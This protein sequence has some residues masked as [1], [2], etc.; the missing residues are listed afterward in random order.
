M[1][2]LQGC[3]QGMNGS[4]K[5]KITTLQEGDILAFDHEHKRIAFLRSSAPSQY[6]FVGFLRSKPDFHL[7]MDN[8]CDSDFMSIA[9]LIS[10][11]TG[12]SIEENRD[13]PAYKSAFRFVR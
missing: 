9:L 13:Y 6:G 11:A 12:L 5:G 1:L 2:R 8:L 10:A 4:D 7:Y 3:F